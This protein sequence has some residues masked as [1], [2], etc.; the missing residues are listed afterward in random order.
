MRRSDIAPTPKER[1][2]ARMREIIIETYEKEKHDRSVRFPNVPDVA[3]LAEGISPEL[4]REILQAEIA[5]AAKFGTF[6]FVV[7]K[8]LDL[9]RVNLE[10]AKRNYPGTAT[11][12]KRLPE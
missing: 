7:E 12:M 8:Q 6:Q 4:Q 9:D 2:A 5:V 1:I 10:I 3:D 11:T